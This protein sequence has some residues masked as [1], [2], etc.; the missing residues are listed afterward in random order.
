MP[1]PHLLSLALATGCLVIAAAALPLACA[2]VG[3]GV[4]G[5]EGGAGRAC[6]LRVR[7]SAYNSVAAQTNAR[8]S[9][10][11][12]GDRLEPGMKAIAVSRDLLAHGLVHRTPVRIDGLDGEY[13]VLDKMARRWRRKIDIYFG[14]D[15]GAAKTW[16]VREV[17]ISWRIAEG[18]SASCPKG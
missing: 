15:V 7:A 18:S 13:R 2:H 16:G 17:T 4:E 1:R 11:A 12:W 3:P 8:P 5:G 14:T 6:T 10:A 9:L